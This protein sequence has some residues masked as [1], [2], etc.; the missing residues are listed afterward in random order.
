VWKHVLDLDPT[1]V[2]PQEF[3]W[4]RDEISKSLV[5]T[6]VIDGVE[7]APTQILKLINYSCESDTP[8]RCCCS[9]A[10]LACT[11]CG[12]CYAEGNC[13]KKLNKTGTDD[14]ENEKYPSMWI[15]GLYRH[16][17]AKFI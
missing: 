17:H 15:C 16:A 7:L 5:P 12:A 2:N 13:Y 11:I 9:N 1:Q 3:G 14:N 10:E 6:I 4:L 8:Y